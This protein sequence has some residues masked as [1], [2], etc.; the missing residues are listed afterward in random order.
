MKI[1]KILAAVSAAAVAATTMAVSAFA[2]NLAIPAGTAIIGFG[3]TTWDAAFWG[4]E[5]DV[6]NYAD[7]C[8]PVE[9]TGNGT[10]TLKIDLSGG[11]DAINTINEETGEPMHLTTATGIGAMGINTMFSP[12]DEAYDGFGINITS[13]KF[14]GVETKKE[15]VTSYTNDEDGGKRTNIM[16]AWVSYDS[17]KEDHIASDPATANSV[18]TDFADAWT[19]CEVTFDVFGLAETDAPAPA[20]DAVVDAGDKQSPDTGVEGI[21]VIGGVAVLAAG[22]LFVAKKRK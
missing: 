9:I 22:A 8:T 10:Y 7:Y 5:D 6:L 18:L 15:G 20:P 3:D 11:Y 4:K 21:A 13:I 17:T 19:T 16:N 14:D 12:D 2:A 1:R